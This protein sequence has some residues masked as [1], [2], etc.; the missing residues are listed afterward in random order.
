MQLLIVSLGVVWENPSDADVSTVRA[1][2]GSCY[3]KYWL[4]NEVTGCHIC[5][6]Y[7]R[8]DLTACWKLMA[9]YWLLLFVYRFLAIFASGYQSSVRDCCEVGA[10][11]EAVREI[12]IHIGVSAARL[13]SFHASQTPQQEKTSSLP[14]QKQRPA[15]QTNGAAMLVQQFSNIHQQKQRPAQQP[16]GEQ[17][18]A[19][20]NAPGVRPVSLLVG[21][22]GL[23]LFAI[24][25]LP[26]MASLPDWG[27][28]MDSMM[29]FDSGNRRFVVPWGPGLFCFSLLLCFH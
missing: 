7:C 24:A 1:S 9:Y 29:V 2:V 25:A 12:N 19:S 26:M 8:L 13:T 28:N 23:N 22:G 21:D 3:L 18:P 16:N 10:D 14:Q 17:C 6:A 4:E 27:H 5:C 20:V 15:Q 11:V